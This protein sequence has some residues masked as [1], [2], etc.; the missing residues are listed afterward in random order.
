MVDDYSGEPERALSH[1]DG[2]AMPLAADEDAGRPPAPSGGVDD[3]ASPE[4]AALTDQMLNELDPDGT[5][6]QSFAP[7]AALK[8]E[9]DALAH[10]A[11]FLAQ[12]NLGTA[13]SIDD[14]L[15]AGVDGG[16][17]APAQARAL[18][19]LYDSFLKQK[20]RDGAAT[21]EVK[22]K[23]AAIRRLES[24]ALDRKRKLA[25]SL[26]AMTTIEC[27][28]GDNVATN[29]LALLEHVGGGSDGYAFASLEGRRKAIV[30]RAHERMAQWL[31]YFQANALAGDGGPH[32]AGLH[33]VV[34]EAFGEKTD[35]EA[36]KGLAQAWR[37]THEWLRRR[38]NDA[39][40]TIT[41]LDKGGLPQSHD[42][43]AL[44]AAGRDKWKAAIAPLLERARMTNVL[45]GDVLT[46]AEF[47]QALDDVWDSVVARGW[48][49]RKPAKDAIGPP[50][51]QTRFL[52]FKDAKSWLAYARDF[53]E[54]DAFSAMMSHINLMARDIA[55]MEILGPDPDSVIEWLKQTIMTQAGRAMAG[56]PSRFKG[57]LK[58]AVDEAKRAAARLD[59]LWAA[60]QGTLETPVNQQLTDTL[61][62]GRSVLTGSVLGA[63]VLSSVSELG[64]RILARSFTGAALLRVPFDTA[65]TFAIT[66]PRD[67]HAAG[68][69]LESALHVLNSQARYVGTLEGPAWSSILSDRALTWSAL[70]PW[71]QA[72]KHAFAMAMMRELGERVEQSFGELHQGLQ[73]LMLRHDLGARE[74]DIMRKAPLH[75]PHE[76]VAM[77]R[78]REIAAVDEKLGARLLDTV[79]AETDHAVPSGS[80]RA[81]TLSG[82]ESRSGT[83]YAE[84]RGSFAEFKS[85]AAAYA[86]SHGLRIAVMIASSDRGVR[87]RGGAYA[88]ALLVTSTVSGALA[89]ALKEI[90]AG[91]DPQAHF[92]GDWKAFWA[93]AMREGGGAGLYGD[94]LF[95]DLNHYGDGFT[96]R[97]RGASGERLSEVWTLTGGII[98]ETGEGKETHIGRELAK[99]LRA[100][101]PGG[102][103]WYIQQ[104]YERVVLDQLHF[105]ID[106]EANKAFKRVQQSWRRNFG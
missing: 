29:A 23:A 9:M 84:L 2:E 28:L 56:K 11:T 96:R 26:K 7:A 42:A 57:S 66:A 46:D 35:D 12:C 1:D 16:A 6:T 93:A 3:P 60:L 33:N 15:K 49:E 68:L 58:K 78:P 13:W 64:A 27:A 53:G 88:G 77:L 97:L 30:A 10:L 105:L 71:T 90:A 8:A 44:R 62:A 73:R 106:P 75:R 14:C 103:F 65:T 80:L 18:K 20:A 72:T 99:L 17:L 92:G 51:A 102:A 81:S 87:A 86:M 95:N 59:A 50:Q 47:D 91:R 41:R 31:A 74:W 55:A 34:R 85:F 38:F 43:R 67:A 5:L 61:V 21:A 36:A 25:R 98:G 89:L 100:N 79:L 4:E 82:G 94:F 101:T 37:D 22:A 39:G 48:S 24:E 70:T 69:I 76:D 83:L 52:I 45:T 104:A 63:G 40:G 19:D 32:K 54:G